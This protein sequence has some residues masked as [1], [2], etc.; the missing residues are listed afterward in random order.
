MQSQP[1]LSLW[2]RFMKR[3]K[4]VCNAKVASGGGQHPGYNLNKSFTCSRAV[5]QSLQMKGH[6]SV[7]RPSAKP[8]STEIEAVYHWRVKGQK[9]KVHWA[10]SRSLRK[11]W[12]RSSPMVPLL[13]FLNTV[14]FFCLILEKSLILDINLECH[15]SS[16][17]GPAGVMVSEKKKPRTRMVT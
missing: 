15:R 16:C 4:S 1:W 12:Q 7:L 6:H 8:H 14:S 5:L 11:R 9:V 10:S 13:V 3:C 17:P 2:S